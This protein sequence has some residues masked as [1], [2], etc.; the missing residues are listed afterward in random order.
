[1][2]LI[3]ACHGSD[4]LGTHAEGSAGQG[5]SGVVL[6]EPGGMIQEGSGDELPKLVEHGGLSFEIV[7]TATGKRIPGKLT[8]SGAGKTHSPRLSKGDVG[9]EE[10]TSLSAFNRVFSLGG[11]GVVAVPVGTYEVTASRG[12]EWTIDT[13]KVTVTTKGAELHAHITH[14]VDTP[15]WLSADF[16]VHAASSP[17]SRVPM[18]DRVYEFVADG[19]DMIV[20]TDHNVVANYQ[21]IIAELHAENYLASATGDE[22]TTGSWGHFGAFPLPHS[23]EVEGH[24]AIPVAKHTPQDIFRDVRERAPDAIIDIHHPRLEAAIGYFTLGK[25]DP[26]RDRATRKGFSYDF[27]AVEVLNGYQDTNRKTIDR[28]L[29]DWFALLDRGH[30]ITATG[31]SDTHHLTYNLGGY[32]RNYVRLDND[33]P[34]TVTA[35]DVA[36]AVKA[37]HSFFTTGP[38]VGFHVG[39]T[40]IGDL[41]PAPGGKA[42][43]EITVRAA[44]WVSVS[45]VILY[46]AGKEVKRWTL[47]PLPGGGIAPVDRFHETFALDVPHDTYAVVR[48]EGDRS[49]SPVVGGGTGVN[50]TPFAMTNPIFLDTNGNGKYD[51][52]LPHGDHVEHAE[53][54]SP[55]TCHAASDCK[56]RSECGCSCKAVLVTEPSTE[57]CDKTCNNPDVCKGYTATCDLPAQ[58]CYAIPAAPGH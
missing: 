10:D 6:D 53:E 17:D 31:N 44:P 15:H 27:D 26:E 38:I 48:V 30:L 46:V 5:S 8:L 12:P 55:S 21:P 45:R 52:V 51:P 4:S 2:L 20:S 49:L 57:D 42:T 34:A 39:T 33:D 18:R 56:L 3:A 29:A 16:H 25:F 35:V 7:D 11:V 50:V 28:V 41:A 9:T 32:P 40:D 47:P 24:G 19:V 43:A 37:H 54:D 1:M 36:R 13:Q 58:T 23:M 22:I 14:V